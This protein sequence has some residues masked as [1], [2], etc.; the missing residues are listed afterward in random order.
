MRLV[1]GAVTAALVAAPLAI[2]PA[3]TAHAYVES[4]SRPTDGVFHFEGHGWGHGHGLSQWGAEG[5]ASQGVSA[6][7]ILDA[8]YPGTAQ[9]TQAARSIRV[10]IGEDDHADV[11]TKA[12]SGL[13]VHDLASGAKYA[14]PTGPAKYRITTDSAGMH[15]QSYTTAWTT[16]STGGKSTWTGPLQF[17]G[18]TPLRLYFSDGSSRDYRGV[19]RGV[20]TGTTSLNVVN[21]LDLEQYLYGVVPRES[22][23]SWHAAALRA[24]AV[25]ARSYSTYKL[26]HAASG[27]SYDICSTTSCQVYGGK[28]LYTSGGS[29]IALEQASTNAAVDQTKGVVRT[30]NGAAIFAEFSSS[31]GGWATTGSQ[32]YLS[33]HAD[34]WDAIASP[35]HYWTGYITASQIE[36]DFPSVGHLLRIK[37]TRRDGNGEW[38]GRVKDVTL[39]GVDSAGHAT[40]VATT[41]GGI[42]GVKTWPASSTGLRGTWWHVIPQYNAALVTRSASPVVVLPPGNA[43]TDLTVRMKNTGTTGWPASSVHLAVSSPAGAADPMAG[44]STT[45][46]TYVSNVTNPGAASVEPGETAAFVVHLDASKVA[47]GTYVKS[48]RVQLGSAA[49]FGAATTWSVYVHDPTYTSTLAGVTG[50]ASGDPNAPPPVWADNTVVVPRDGSTSV[51]VKVK[52]TSNVTWPLHGGVQLATSGPRWRASDSA[53]PEWLSTSTVG[54]ATAVDGVSGATAVAPGQV[55]VFPLTLHGNGKPLGVTTETFEAK[56]TPYHWLDGALVTLRIV[57]YDAHTSRVAEVVSQPV[58]THLLAYPGD[59]RTLVFRLRNL[60]SGAWPVGT[61]EVL[62]TADPVDRVD[63]LKT[64]AWKSATRTNPLAANVSR[65]GAASVYPGEVGEYRVPIDPTN[66]AAATYHELFQPVAGTARYGPV[67]GADVT[68]SAATFTAAITRN[69]TGIVVPRTGVATYVVE[70]KNTGNTWW[71]VNSSVRLY[72]PSASATSTWLTTTR[73]TALDSNV[74][75]PGATNVRPGEVGKFVFTIG[76][77]GRAAGTYTETYGAVWEWWRNTGLAIPITYTIK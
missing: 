25:A 54:P 70:L 57:R 63:A 74:T 24:Q 66:K 38:G 52:N 17:E 33:A 35:H 7:S 21:V 43:K 65:P 67:T 42:Y 6:T 48:Y 1:R 39:E 64:A 75:R 40:S 72:G 11:M 16:W 46:G 49:P 28:T 76:G 45:P 8:Y 13:A 41:G 18:V 58:A 4:V 29:T 15:V 32:P 22:P 2:L 60:G 47:A 53:G 59:K 51:N 20:K 31:N 12:V 61:D 55:A 68:V 44:N 34:P 27:S 3:Q 26:T 5:A 62:G 71:S 10:L 19:L 30:Y 77:N 73:P 37:V 23:S 50:T 9:A 56:Y 14:L 69:T 36:A